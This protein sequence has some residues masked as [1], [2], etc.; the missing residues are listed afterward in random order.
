MGDS[1]CVL[2]RS[3]LSWWQGEKE[4]DAM[5]NQKQK[6]EFPA[7]YDPRFP[8]HAV[9]ARL[10]PYLRVIVERFQ[11]E[12]VVL[13]GSY[14]YGDPT[15]HSDFDLLIIR[16]G[17]RSSKASNLEIRNAIWDIKAPAASFTF[18]SRTPEEVENKLKR[19]SPIFQDIINRGVTLYA[20]QAN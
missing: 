20:A 3:P 2:I 6:I 16:K 4:Y 9:A 17:I 18:L 7:L 5:T 1:S 10:E 14:A 8:V 12:K 11:P 15:D 13:F 19:G